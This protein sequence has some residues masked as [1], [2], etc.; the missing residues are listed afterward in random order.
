MPT[1]VKM[2]HLLKLDP[3]RGTDPLQP[4]PGE[5]VRLE[6]PLPSGTNSDSFARG[7]LI[8]SGHQTG[9]TAVV[10]PINSSGTVLLDERGFPQA[11]AINVG[12]IHPIHER[13]RHLRQQG[14]CAIYLNAM[15]E[16]SL[17]A[18]IVD[19][20]ESGVGFL[21]RTELSVDDRIEVALVSVHEPSA[22][23]LPAV[24]RT[25]KA[26]DDCC[27]RVGCELGRRLNPDELARFVT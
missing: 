20:S 3:I 27:W 14:T 5:I 22:V 26:V 16:T 12:S 11:V 18:E 21:V 13:R 19:V 25:V 8:N 15:D 4:I 2:S 7:I 9:A 24:V 1:E 17:V 6:P 23:I 10:Y